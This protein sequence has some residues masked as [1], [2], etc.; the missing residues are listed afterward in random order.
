MIRNISNKI[1]QQNKEV[2]KNILK[3][4]IYYSWKFLSPFKKKIKIGEIKKVLVVHPRM[5]GDLIVS[6]P[7]IRALAEKYGKVDVLIR[8]EM[9]QVLSGN[10]NIKELIKYNKFEETVK[11]IKNKY[12]LAI[13]VDPTNF[14]MKYLC[15]KANIKYLIGHESSY[16][17]SDLLL[18][19]RS[20]NDNSRNV[21]EKY[22]E[23]AKLAGAHIKNPKLEFY[24]SKKDEKEVETLLK[25]YKIKKFVIFHSGKRGVNFR[26]YF[27]YSKNWAEI[28]DYIIKKY[29]LLI[30]LTGSKLDKNKIQEIMKYTQSKKVF[31]F[32]EKT[33]IKQLGCLIKK[34]NLLIS[35]DTAPVHIA[36]AFNKKMIVLNMEFPK[37]WHPWMD[38]KNYVLFDNPHIEQVKRE[39]DRFLK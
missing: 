3:D 33:N 23:L 22:L 25:K 35:L 20:K 17:I 37:L 39:V 9:E 36:S 18:S 14:E 5:I 8:K 38:K 12:D 19:A 34:A 10:P 30:I 21:V 11:K 31:N 15:L 32:C 16:S 2:V 7:M 28:A 29:K 6:T 4:V 24:L 13:I 1:P 27:W 26:K